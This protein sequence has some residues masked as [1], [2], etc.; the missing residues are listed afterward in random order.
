MQ[1]IH[2]YLIMFSLLTVLFVI[3]LHLKQENKY[4][5]QHENCMNY[6]NYDYTDYNCKLCDSLIKHQYYGRN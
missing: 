4:L 1:K 2:Y 3:I 6:Y 5:E